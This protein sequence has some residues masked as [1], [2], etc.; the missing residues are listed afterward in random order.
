MYA[1]VTPDDGIDST[2]DIPLHSMDQHLTVLYN[3]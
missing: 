1:V 3:Y 2:A